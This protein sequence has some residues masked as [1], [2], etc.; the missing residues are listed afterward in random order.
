MW[1]AT[2]E[3]RSFDFLALGRTEREAK[4][5]LLDGWRRH[6]LMTG[7]QLSHVTTDD[8]TTVKIAA[9]QCLSGHD[10]I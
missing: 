6:C 2:C 1:I 10:L 7:A 3:T 4:D 8:I 9:G 5:A